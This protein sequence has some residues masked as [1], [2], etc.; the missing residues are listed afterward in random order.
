MKNIFNKPSSAPR[1]SAS[2]CRPHLFNFFSYLFLFGDYLTWFFIKDHIFWESLLFLLPNSSPMLFQYNIVREKLDF[3]IDSI[4]DFAVWQKIKDF[5]LLHPQRKKIIVSCIWATRECSNVEGINLV[6]KKMFCWNLDSRLTNSLVQIIF[7]LFSS[8][9]RVNSNL[10]QTDLMSK[11][12]ITGD[13]RSAI[14]SFIEVILVM[15]K[16]KTVKK[17]LLSYW[18]VRGSLLDNILLAQYTLRLLPIWM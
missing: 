15:S 2:Q 11:L 13:G 9:K 16:L 7:C 17:V 4:F 8:I 10:L 1:V 3:E 6:L 14:N 12:K 18:E 5:L